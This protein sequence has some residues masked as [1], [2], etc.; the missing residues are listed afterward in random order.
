MK[1]CYVAPKK[2][3]NDKKRH[4]LQRALIAA[5]MMIYNFNLVFADETTQRIDSAGDTAFGYIKLA[6]LWLFVF[7]IALEIMK[8]A[9]DGEKDA[10]WGILAKYG[11]LY[12]C[13]L[14]AKPFLLWI[15]G[16]FE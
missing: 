4:A 3:T 16:I 6:A 9:K 1:V 2:H 13:I 5:Q 10:A 8:K 11:I 7:L 15:G 14:A 12:A